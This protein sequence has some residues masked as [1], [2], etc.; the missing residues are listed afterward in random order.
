MKKRRHKVV[1][2]LFRRKVEQRR[3]I[4]VVQGR[5]PTP[6]FVSFSNSDQRYF[7]ELY[8]SWNVC[9]LLRADH[10]SN[11]KRGSV[12]IYYKETLALIMILIRYLNESLFCEVTIGLKTFIIRTVYRSPGQNFDEFVSFPSSFQFL[13]QDISNHKP[14]L[15][16]LL[17]DYNARN[18]KWWQHDI[19]TTEG[20]QL[21][22]AVTQGSNN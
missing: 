4:K 6:D 19:T 17:G 3:C 2:T 13:L 21:F 7:N 15:T 9:C 11:A 20:T 1:S 8:F 12:F 14:Y 5:N 22:R 10:P 16:L 18:T